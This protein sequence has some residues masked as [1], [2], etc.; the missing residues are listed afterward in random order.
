M[1]RTPLRHQSPP[2]DASLRPGFSLVEVI[3]A[4]VILGAALLAMA[5]F[6]VKYQQVDA[7]TRFVVKAQQAAN[8]RLERVRTAQPYLSLDTM[9]TTESSLSGLPGYTRTTTVTRVGGGPA[10]TVNYRIVTVRVRT[11]GNRSTISKSSIVG[12]F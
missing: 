9:A 12:A 11:P 8:E 6:T 2:V 5:G 1:M 4:A 3:V 10:D 7:Y